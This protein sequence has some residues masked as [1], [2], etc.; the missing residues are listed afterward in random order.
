MK[1]GKT[2][3]SSK[4]LGVICEGCLKRQL[5]R[6]KSLLIAPQPIRSKEASKPR[7]SAKQELILIA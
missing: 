6:A 4:P 1:V 2:A 7:G 3:C 5:S